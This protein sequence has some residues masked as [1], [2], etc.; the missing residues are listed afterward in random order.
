MVKGKSRLRVRRLQLMKSMERANGVDRGTTGKEPANRRARSVPAARWLQRLGWCLVAAACLLSALAIFRVPILTGLAK[1]WVVNEPVA[2]ADA[3][4][5]LGG[6][7]ENRPFA[8]AKL[9]HAG[10]A[11]KI[12]YMDVKLD[13]AAR[14]GIGISERELTRRILMSN[15]VPESALVAVGEGVAS[16]FDE[17]RAVRDWMEITGAK[18]IVI[19]TDLFHTRRVRW[20]FRHELGEGPF[21]I[22]VQAVPLPGYGPGDWW[23]HEDGLIAFESEVIKTIYYRCKY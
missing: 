7:P 4:V 10:V 19:P 2:K 11:P 20:I 16:T 9:Y 14:M 21:Q 1:V 23:R 15:N 12:L 17:S 5:V 22:R 13:A 3:I 6:G 18:S 8:A